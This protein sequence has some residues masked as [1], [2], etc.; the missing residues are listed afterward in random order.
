MSHFWFQIL[1]ALRRQYS[2]GGCAGVAV[3]GRAVLH[4]SASARWSSASCLGL[5]HADLRLTNYICLI[6]RVNPTFSL[7]ATLECWDSGAGGIPLARTC[8]SG[9]CHHFQASGFTAPIQPGHK[10]VPCRSQSCMFGVP[11]QLPPGRA[12]L[13]QVQGPSSRT[14]APTS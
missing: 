3:R 8:T 13:S 11:P 12:A 5:I 10:R 1:G 2:M 9:V 4:K 7:W 14:S 6:P